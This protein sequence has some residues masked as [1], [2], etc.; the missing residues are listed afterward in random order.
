MLIEHRISISR[1]IKSYSKSE[2]ISNILCGIGHLGLDSIFRVGIFY[3]YMIFN[4]DS[5][6]KFESSL[7]TTIGLFLL[8]DFIYYWYHRL[9][10]NSNI[11]WIIHRI[12]HQSE[13]FNYSVGL[14]QAWFHKLSA[15]WIYIPPA[16]LGF[17]S[18]DYIMVASVHAIAQIWTHTNLYSF[19]NS[20]IRYLLVTPSHHRLHHAINK[21]YLNTNYGGILSVWDHIFGTTSLEDESIK[22]IYGVNDNYFN[23]EV[24]DVVTSNWGRLA[25]ELAKAHSY[26]TLSQKLK[27]LFSAPGSY[28][29][30]NT[31]THRITTDVAPAITH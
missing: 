18:H 21:P 31:S 4:N 12:H 11:F 25:R 6:L 27:V 1:G 28:P 22:K 5:L 29:N 26:P 10:H 8:I 14:R 16:F 19:K 13:H 17:S 2:T 7:F 9:S 15:F 20:I 3:L 23:D 24:N 30:F